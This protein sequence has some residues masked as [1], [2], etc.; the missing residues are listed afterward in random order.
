ME[1]CRKIA[2]STRDLGNILK[3]CAP[4]RSLH[5]SHAVLEPAL[6][7]IMEHLRTGG[8]DLELLSLHAK[9]D[10]LN[11]SDF[12]TV[13]KLCPNLQQLAFSINDEVGLYSYNTGY[14]NLRIFV[15]SCS[16]HSKFRVR[17][18][19]FYTTPSDN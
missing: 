11:E 3:A 5:S 19:M 1:P 9:E 18:L 15:V 2:T 4:V 10:T 12:E 16:T 14:E 6:P 13:C 7:A 8:S 17:I